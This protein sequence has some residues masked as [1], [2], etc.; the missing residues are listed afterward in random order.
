[1]SKE[2]FL[3]VSKPFDSWRGKAEEY[4]CLFILGRDPS[5]SD[6]DWLGPGRRQQRTVK[7]HYR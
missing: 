7:E 5:L 3:N 1:M 6:L 4:L 2:T